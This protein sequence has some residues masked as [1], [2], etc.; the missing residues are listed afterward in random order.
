LAH[1]SEIRK[2]QP[3][4]EPVDTRPLCQARRWQNDV[5]VTR[6]AQKKLAQILDT[7]GVGAV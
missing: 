6:L 7:A 4:G 1:R 2:P 5:K 3:E